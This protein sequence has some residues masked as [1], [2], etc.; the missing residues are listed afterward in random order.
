MYLNSLLQKSETVCWNLSEMW[1]HYSAALCFNNF[2]Q[3]YSVFVSCFMWRDA[4][5]FARLA[6]SSRCTLG[7]LPAVERVCVFT[8]TLGIS[9][10]EN[11]GE[12]RGGTM[13][14]PLQRLWRGM[15]DPWSVVKM[16]SV[17]CSKPRANTMRVVL[18]AP[19][20]HGWPWWVLT[21]KIL[22]FHMS[23]SSDRGPNVS[24][25]LTSGPY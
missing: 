17:S 21:Q 24:T 14:C 25:N 9:E 3:L 23:Y 11:S 18:C 10:L 22:L 1:K 13:N 16:S 12:L 15:C 19:W 6:F 7:E 4:F 8:P 20:R 2:I 5:W